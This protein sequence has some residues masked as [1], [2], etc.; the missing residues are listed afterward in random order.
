MTEALEFLVVFLFISSLL[1]EVALS[2][3]GLV[4]GRVVSQVDAC[5]FLFIFFFFVVIA[6]L[7]AFVLRFRTNQIQI[8]RRLK[9][10]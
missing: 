10:R 6:C 3:S 9:A 2:S 8:R 1:Q 7:S 4:F 5:L